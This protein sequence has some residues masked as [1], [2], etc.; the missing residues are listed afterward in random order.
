MGIWRK[1]S[2]FSKRSALKMGNNIS[3]AKLGDKF[4]L[5]DLPELPLESILERLS[6]SELCC[7]ATL[8]KS[9][10]DRCQSD[11]LWDKLLKQK[12]GHVIGDS[13]YKQWLCHVDSRNTQIRQQNQKSLFG[14]F[15]WIRPK[16]HDADRERSNHSAMD[17]YISLT[18]G[19]FWFPAQVFNREVSN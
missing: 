8:C 16:S 19:K 1:I 18:N 5:L 14:S 9:L 3:K 2:N 17:L 4:W 10:R 12:W 6:P 13:A 11:Y 15:L 7:M